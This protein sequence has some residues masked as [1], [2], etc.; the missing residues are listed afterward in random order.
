MGDEGQ[1]TLKFKKN[2][3]FATITQTQSL[4]YE[5]KENRLGARFALRR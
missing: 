4:Y 1:H 2:D 3:T 5:T